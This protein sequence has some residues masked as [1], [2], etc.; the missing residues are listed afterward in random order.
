MG[1]VVSSVCPQGDSLWLQLC[2]AGPEVP[3]PLVRSQR[4]CAVHEKQLA[5][6]AGQLGRNEPRADVAHGVRP[7]GHKA[8]LFW[9]AMVQQD[10][11]AQSKHTVREKLGEPKGLEL[12]QLSDDGL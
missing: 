11:L 5:H 6:G 10:V 3:L 2:A 9:A 4:N 8:P 1:A 7:P 12:R